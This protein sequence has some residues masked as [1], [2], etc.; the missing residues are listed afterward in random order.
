MWRS[1]ESLKFYPTNVLETQQVP[2]NERTTIIRGLCNRTPGFMGS[3]RNWR[4]HTF[5]LFS[6]YDKLLTLTFALRSTTLLSVIYNIKENKLCAFCLLW[7][8]YDINHFKSFQLVWTLRELVW[9]HHPH[10]CE[11]HIVS[12]TFSM[13]TGTGYIKHWRNS[14]NCEAQKSALTA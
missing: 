11:P 13:K 8:S 14:C 10:V 4:L 12:L 6:H 1:Y 3:V 7:Y 9:E 5:R 2:H